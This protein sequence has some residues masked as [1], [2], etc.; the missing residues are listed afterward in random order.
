MPTGPWPP[1]LLGAVCT[2]DPGGPTKRSPHLLRN[3]LLLPASH[4]RPEHG[5]EET[6]VMPASGKRVS[7]FTWCFQ[8]PQGLPPQDTG[9][10][11]NFTWDLS[12]T[13]DH[14]P[15]NIL[16]CASFS[17][18]GKASPASARQSEPY[19]P[20]RCPRQHELVAHAKSHLKRSTAMCG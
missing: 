12:L 13:S 3:S 5:R 2:L 9:S 18:T 14:S 17:P 7:V 15:Q 19:S 11:L 20:V 1:T 16:I 6:K 10:I 8:T 4:F